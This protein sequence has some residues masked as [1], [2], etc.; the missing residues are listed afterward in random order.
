MTLQSDSEPGRSVMRR[1]DDAQRLSV[2]ASAVR[3]TAPGTMT[4]G[5]YGLF[6]WELGPRAPGATPHFHKT[7]SEAFYVLEGT[8]TLGDG[9]TWHQAGVGDFFY[10]P[11]GGV[12][13]F[14]NDADEPA[15][16]LIIFSPGAPREGYFTELAEIRASGRTLTPEQW[17]ELYARHDQYEATPG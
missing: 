4:D 17:T 12:H 2:G 3:F 14:R 1:L 16:M 5:R 9:T 6:R 8:V 13:A 10:V 7:F 11:E 15:A